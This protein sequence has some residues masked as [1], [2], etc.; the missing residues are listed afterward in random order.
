MDRLDRRKRILCI[1][2]DKTMHLLLKSQL[3]N[4]GGYKSLHATSGN[5]ALATLRGS[6]IDLVILDI[7]MP[8]IDGFQMLEYLKEN[9]ATRKIPII[10]LSS[11][12]R[13]NLKVKAL[14][15]GA[16]DFMVKPFTGPELIARIN[17]VLRRNTDNKQEIIGDVQG[18]LQELGLFDLLH[19][20]SFSNKSGKITFPEM[21]GELVTAAGSI[22]SVRQGSWQNEEALL[23]LFFLEKGSFIIQYGEQEG[24][25]LGSIESLLFSIARNLDE[26]H[27]QIDM[28]VPQN[29]LLHLHAYKKEGLEIEQLGEES[30]TSLVNLIFSMEGTLKANLDSVRKGLQNG[31]ILVEKSRGE[32]SADGNINND[33]LMQKHQITLQKKSEINNRN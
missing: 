3:V 12:S 15:H 9:E 7:N 14:E 32:H 20:F 24:T 25:N 19:M 30:P 33:F 22:L 2:D 28:L 11:L 29:A 31:T 18:R 16:D 27:D 13:E 10:F 21:D 8:K 23:R 1:D 5:E 17:A 4:S 26:L 6:Q